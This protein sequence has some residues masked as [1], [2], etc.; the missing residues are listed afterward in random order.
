MNFLEFS[1][2]GIFFQLQ[3]G[4]VPSFALFYIYIIGE[5]LRFFNEEENRVYKSSFY[6]IWSDE[7]KR[8]KNGKI[9]PF[10]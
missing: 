8:K 7:T 6:E 1:Y 5:F 9:R 2:S 4:N 3:M 10:F